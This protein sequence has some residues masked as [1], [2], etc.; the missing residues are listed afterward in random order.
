MTRNELIPPELKT[1]TLQEWR[2]RGRRLFGNDWRTWKFRC[3]VCRH[4]AQAGDWLDAGA[5]EGAIA[6]SCIGRWNGEGKQGDS[7]V[8]RPAG[9]GPCMY[10]GGGLFKLNPVTVVSPDGT[11]NQVFAFADDEGK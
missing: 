11:Q 10:A 3:P 7:P 5:P 9:G 4:V 2:E 1:M 8:R 6:F